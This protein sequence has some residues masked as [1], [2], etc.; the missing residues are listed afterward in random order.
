MTPKHLA[1]IPDGNRRWAKAQGLLAWKGHEV[2][3]KRAEEVMRMAFDS[4][5]QY[6]T[7]WAAS[8]ANLEKR[9]KQEVAVLVDV[10][11][12]FIK[13]FLKSDE[14]TKREVRFQLIGKGR[15]I[16]KDKELNELS[17]TLEEKTKKFS[18]YYSTV[19]FG[20]DGQKEMLEAINRIKKQESKSEIGGDELR[21]AL[22]TGFLPD[23]DLVIRTGGE[24][25]WSAGFLMWQTANSQFYFT[26]TFWPDFDT[27]ELKK[28]FADYSQRERRMGK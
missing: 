19:L 20:Y 1:I 27:E 15:E 4:G 10:L 26:E 12:K 22:L 18:K 3:A 11:K 13:D 9:P 5:V 28:A 7:F 25:H 6:F 16:V 24:P 21:R 17:E 8:L 23:V 14:L 2:G